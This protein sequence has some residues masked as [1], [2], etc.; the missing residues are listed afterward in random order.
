MNL[1]KKLVH[2]YR[3][4]RQATAPTTHIVTIFT[5]AVPVLFKLSHWP[6]LR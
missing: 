6:N 2:L 1:R 4:T 5:L 3:R